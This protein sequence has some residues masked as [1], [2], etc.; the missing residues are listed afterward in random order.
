MG[1]KKEEVVVEAVEE[2]VE[3]LIVTVATEALNIRRKP[4]LT[5]DILA[6]VRKGDKLEV[7]EDQGEWLKVKGGYTMA[8]YVTV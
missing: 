4:S 1:K 7:V 8:K 2:K 6:V 5:A 3:A